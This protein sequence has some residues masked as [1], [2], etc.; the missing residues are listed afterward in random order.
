LVQ[1]DVERFKELYFI[2]QHRRYEL[3]IRLNRGSAKG[4]AELATR[5]DALYQVA[6]PDGAV[7]CAVFR[8]PLFPELEPHLRLHDGRPRR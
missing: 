1:L 7:L 5:S 3:D 4:V 2:P 8:G 6:T